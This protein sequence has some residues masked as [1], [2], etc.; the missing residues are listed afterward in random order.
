MDMDP[1]DG[2]RFASRGGGGGGVSNVKTTKVHSVSFYF[3][4]Q[5]AIH[6]SK[7]S[8]ENRVRV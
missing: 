2:S 4:I 5:P 6:R 7:W 3:S 8:L 1:G